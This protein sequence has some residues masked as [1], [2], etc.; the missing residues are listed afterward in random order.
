MIMA[1]KQARDEVNKDAKLIG[2]SLLT[3]MSDKTLNDIGLDRRSILVG[4]LATIAQNCK[5]D[6]LV[7]SPG[8]IELISKISSNFLYVTPGIRLSDS[9][10]DH[11]KVFSPADALK[12]GATYLVIGRSITDAEDPSKVVNDILLTIWVI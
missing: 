9:K 6:G 2:V 10:Q 8:D 7:C 5:I 12:L 4:K 11:S 3:S 1:A